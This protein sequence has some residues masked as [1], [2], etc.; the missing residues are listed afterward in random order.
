MMR[1]FENSRMDKPQRYAAI[2]AESKPV[3][4]YEELNQQNPQKFYGKRVQTCSAS[5]TEAIPKQRLGEE[6]R[7]I[8]N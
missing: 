2:S 8:T 6:H 3:M 1:S 4:V 5:L 7:E